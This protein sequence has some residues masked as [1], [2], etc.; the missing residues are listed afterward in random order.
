[1][2]KYIYTYVFIYIYIYICI[3]IYIFIYIYLYIY[4]HIYIY[5][6]IYIYTF[7]YIFVYVYI[8]IYIYMYICSYAGAAYNAQ[9]RGRIVSPFL[10][11]YICV[12][13]LHFYTHVLILTDIFLHRYCTWSIGTWQHISSSTWVA[14]LYKKREVGMSY[15]TYTSLYTRVRVFMSIK[16]GCYTNMD[17]WY[18]MA[19]W[20]CH[21]WMSYVDMS[22]VVLRYH[23]WQER[24]QESGRE[25][26]RESARARPRQR[27]RARARDVT[28]Q[29]VI[30]IEYL[31]IFPYL[32]P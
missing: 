20:R 15:V 17:L 7:M 27:K 24:E 19:Q 4:I 13:T 22:S 3:Y 2:F 10:S 26:A 28:N 14:C 9:T 18:T 23:T 11:L 29:I 31:I 5:I 25:R 12:Y 21:I 32:Y 1:V 8:Y 6:Y 16:H 30:Y